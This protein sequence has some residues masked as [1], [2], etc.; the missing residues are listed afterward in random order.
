M[1]PV[2]TEDSAHAT[3]GHDHERVPRQ[4]QPGMRRPDD[5]A[6][7]VRAGLARRPYLWNRTMWNHDADRC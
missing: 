6:S 2:R 4:I 7:C 3:R 5:C 1:D